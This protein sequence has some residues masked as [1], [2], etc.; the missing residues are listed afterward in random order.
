MS[1]V[2]GYGGSLDYQEVFYK[3]EIIFKIIKSTEKNMYNIFEQY[4]MY[5]YINIKKKGM[6]GYISNLTV[7]KWGQRSTV[8]VDLH[9]FL[10]YCLLF[11]RL[12]K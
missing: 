6:K 1:L 5:H 12:K 4:S 9:F 8:K 2:K 7:K 10:L 11:E 3:F